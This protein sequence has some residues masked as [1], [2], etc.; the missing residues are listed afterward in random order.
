MPICRQCGAS[1]KDEQ[2]FC[3]LCGASLREET[4]EPAAAEPVEAS[5]PEEVSY[6][7]PE[8]VAGPPEGYHLGDEPKPN[9]A[10][11]SPQAAP[12]EPPHPYGAMPGPGTSGG[13]PDYIPPKRKVRILPIVLGVVIFLAM[14][15]GVLYL[16]FGFLPT[17]TLMGNWTELN[18]GYNF[19]FSHDTIDNG[20]DI[21]SYSYED[22]IITTISPGGQ[23]QSYTVDIEG[24]V[25]IWID[26]TYGELTVFYRTGEMP[27]ALR[28]IY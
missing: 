3:H 28:S 9:M 14:V 5:A 11:P 4:P 17:A 23:R 6:P 7:Q 12:Y 15:G 22:G 25:M 16:L 1:C 2:S 10:P 19:V 26:Q 27:A 13:Y 21:F 20:Q 8:M 18:Y 24:N